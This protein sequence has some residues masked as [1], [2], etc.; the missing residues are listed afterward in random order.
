MVEILKI[1]PRSGKVKA[2]CHPQ[3]RIP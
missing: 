3:R 2:V 1:T